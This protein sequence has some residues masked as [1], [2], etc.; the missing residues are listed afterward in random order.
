MTASQVRTLRRSS[1]VLIFLV[2]SAVFLWGIWPPEQVTRS[3]TIP[4]S[5]RLTLAWPGEIRAGDSQVIRMTISDSEPVGTPAPGA[6]APGRVSSY[7]VLA[8]ARLEMGGLVVVPAGAVTQPLRPGRNI[9]FYWSARPG[10]AGVSAG[11]AWLYFR[12]IPLAGG[13][14]NRMPVLAQPVEIR[15]LELFGL[16]GPSARWM[17]ALGLLAG[18][19]LGLDGLLSRVFQRRSR[20]YLKKNQEDRI[21]Q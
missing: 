15:T 4:E 14:E 9:S 10:A 19:L 5:H 3:V 7:N 18:S 12:S 17:G 2:S 11:V 20:R 1:G 13:L 21:L 8:E 6:P 16:Q